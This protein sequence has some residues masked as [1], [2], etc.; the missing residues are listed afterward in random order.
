MEKT[1]MLGKI[2]G[3]RKMGRQRI[4]WLDSITNSPGMNLSRLRQIRQMVKDKEAWCTVVHGVAES[5]TWLIDR[6]TSSRYTVW[7]FDI[8]IYSEMIITIKLV[9]TFLT[10]IVLIYFCVE[11]FKNVSNFQIY[12]SVLLT[13]VTLYP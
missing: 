3:K 12:N 1:L 13:I 8:Y 10:C 4:R 11:N 6:T 9:N 5:R 7:F 2:E